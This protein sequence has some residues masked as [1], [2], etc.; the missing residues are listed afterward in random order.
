MSAGNGYGQYC[1]LAVG[2]DVVGDIWAL[3]VVRELLVGA[4][5]WAELIDGIP[6]IDP[7]VLADRLTTLVAHGVVERRTAGYRLTPVGERLREPVL[8]LAS[9]GRGRN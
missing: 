1:P 8:E 4:A 3:L 5:R 9:W 7:D 2:L 6:G